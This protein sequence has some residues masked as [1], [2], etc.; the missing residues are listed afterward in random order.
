MWFKFLNVLFQRNK[1]EKETLTYVQKCKKLES[2]CRA[3]QAELHG[4]KPPTPEPAA[5]PAPT[6]ASG[7]MDDIGGYC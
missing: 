6:E 3:L 4:R 7:G 1:S 5:A 2:L